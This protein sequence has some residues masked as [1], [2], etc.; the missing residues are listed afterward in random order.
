MCGEKRCYLCDSVLKA[1][2]GKIGYTFSLLWNEAFDL[3]GALPDQN[4]AKASAP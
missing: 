2:D 4:V 1:W 3:D